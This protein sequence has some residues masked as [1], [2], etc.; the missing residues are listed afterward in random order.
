M[1]EKPIPSIFELTPLNEAYRVDP[2][3]MLDHLRER[4]PVHRNA[5]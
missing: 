1:T 4:C 5:A 2:H 3:A